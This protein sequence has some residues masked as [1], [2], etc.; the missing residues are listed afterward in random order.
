M[1]IDANTFAKKLVKAL[2]LEGRP[3]RRVVLDCEINEVVRVFYEEF[4]EQD[5]SARVVEV[6][7]QFSDHIEMHEG[8]PDAFVNADAISEKMKELTR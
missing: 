3:I 2:G 1:I 8:I 7:S 6:V 5:A 4:L